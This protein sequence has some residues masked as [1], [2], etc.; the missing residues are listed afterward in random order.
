MQVL[1]LIAEVLFLALLILIVVQ[2]LIGRGVRARALMAAA[3]VRNGRPAAD[4]LDR[5]PKLVAEHALRSGVR[6]GAAA[7]TVTFTQTAD[8]RLK[9]GGRFRQFAAWQIIGVGQAGFLWEARQS[10]GLA[11]SIRVIDALFEGQGTL[12]ARAFGAIPLVRA[13]GPEVSLAE[14]YRYL[15]ELPWAPDAMVGNPDLRWRT[16]GDRLVEVSLATE[17]GAVVFFM[18]DDRGDITGMR[19]KG[20]PAKDAAGKPARYDWV[21]TYGSYAQLGSRRVPETAEVGYIYPTG[22]ET[23]FK[24]RIAD[25]RVS[26]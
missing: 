10:S 9:P 26:P 4:M 12:E 7:R 8:L 24:G 25:Y 3:R 21:G 2:V 14:A 13:S 11:S 23:Y 20:R 19:A 1:Q 17:P 18:F 5:L 22:Y 6:P 15:A 16:V